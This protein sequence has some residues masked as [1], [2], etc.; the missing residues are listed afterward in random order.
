MYAFIGVKWYGLVYHSQ[1]GYKKMFFINKKNEDRKKQLKSILGIAQRIIDKSE[2]SDNF[3][4][5]IYRYINGIGLSVLQR[6][7]MQLFTGQE[8]DDVEVLFID[9]GRDV[10]DNN[11]E[12]IYKSV[13]IEN[14]GEMSISLK[15]NLVIPVA[16]NIDRFE[17][18]ITR[19]GAD[20][21]DPFEFD[22]L[23][24]RSILFL[25]IGI[26]IVYNGNHSI[27]SGIIKREGIIH[28][29]EV[30][31]LAPLYE[32]AR[33]DGIHYRDNESNQVIQE[34]RNFELG[35][36]YEIG[37]LLIKNDISFLG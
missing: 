6:L 11:N 19:I 23:N 26:T 5:P 34:V 7:L 22:K 13:S 24:H 31:D 1:W 9:L 21:E 25:P 15:D 20:C 33:F 30:V 2:T 16:W 18:A 10:K 36:I 14:N 12:Y 37:R 4:H 17:S 3:L 32:K 8:V 35:A 27:L 29:T 28:P